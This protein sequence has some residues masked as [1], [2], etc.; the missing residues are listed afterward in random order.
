[1]FN[2]VLELLIHPKQ[3][4][5]FPGQVK[6]R[7]YFVSYMPPIS[8]P[9]PPDEETRGHVTKRASGASSIVKSVCR[10]FT[11]AAVL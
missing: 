11:G 2:F 9:E 10:L 5:F 6:D 3:F 4:P 8:N 7:T 1:M